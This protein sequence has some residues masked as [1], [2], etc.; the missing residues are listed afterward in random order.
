MNKKRFVKYLGLLVDEHLTWEEHINGISKRI[1][2][3]IGI[4]TLLRS[5]MDIDLLVNL[6]YSLVYSHL[7]YGI[8]VWGSACQT[9]LEKI[10]VLQNK[11]VR[12]IS[13]VQH[14][15]IYGEPPGPLPSAD[16]LFKNLEI[17]KLNDIFKFHIVK[18]VFQCLNRESPPTFQG[19][20]NVNSEIH[21]HGTTS[22]VEI[23]RENYFDVG[24]VTESRILHTR[25]SNLINYGGKSLQ[26][27]GPILWNDLPIEIRNKERLNPF[28]YYS[29][30]HYN[31]PLGTTV[32]IRNNN[33]NPNHRNPRQ[34]HRSRLANNAGLNRPFASRWNEQ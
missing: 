9:E 5:S 20:F 26:V 33:N 32:A 16:P 10:Q 19:W 4:I 6:Y 28:K 7:I 23:L 13:K 34:G 3:S 31:D 29:K 27:T 14:F 11:A 8:H 2:R 30:K 12:V 18:F 22:S 1:S 17:L 24:T 21:Q 15:Q 25:Q